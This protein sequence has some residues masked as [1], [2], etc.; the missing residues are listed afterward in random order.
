MAR[1]DRVDNR[2]ED[3][4]SVTCLLL[5]IAAR[6]CDSNAAMRDD[7]DCSQ[8][9]SYFSGAACVHAQR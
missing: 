3:S 4:S 8:D 9:V 5:S 7:L 2:T 1:R 6:S